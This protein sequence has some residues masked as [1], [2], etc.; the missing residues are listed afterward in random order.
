MR[1]LTLITFLIIY[2]L[3]SPARAEYQSGYNPI[4]E[5]NCRYSWGS[6]K[7]FHKNNDGETVP[8]DYPHDLKSVSKEVKK[9]F[10][11][12]NFNFKFAVNGDLIRVSKKSSNY[13]GPD[14]ALKI[15]FQE[16]VENNEDVIISHH[17]DH[18]NDIFINTT[19]FKNDNLINS[20][21]NFHF[22]E[23]DNGTRKHFS[24]SWYGHCEKIN[25]DI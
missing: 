24:L 14:K 9:L 11:S 19:I 6:E 8:L 25:N 2:T 4:E 3:V 23:I 16:V 21:E 12:A 5:Y 15:F 10:S 7:V 20:V 1:Y 22:H 13:K 17:V 18:D